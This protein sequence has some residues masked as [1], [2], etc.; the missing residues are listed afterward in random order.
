MGPE[1][2]IIVW[3]FRPCSKTGVGPGIYIHGDGTII[4]DMFRY[5]R[6]AGLGRGVRCGV[7]DLVPPGA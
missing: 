2:E 6:S 1:G 4:S 5:R 7:R 3:I